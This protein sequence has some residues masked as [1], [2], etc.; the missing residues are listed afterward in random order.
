MKKK[1]TLATLLIVFITFDS[2]AQFKDLGKRIEGKIKRKID[3]KTDR[4]IDKALN[5]G[6]DKIDEGVNSATKKNTDESTEK[7][8]TS[9]TFDFVPGDKALFTDDLQ[10]ENTGDFPSKWN[11]NGSG[12]VVVADGK[13]WLK[14]KGNSFY[15]PQ[16]SSSLPENY[17]I[18]FDLAT[19]G[20]NQKVSSTLNLGIILDDNSGFKTGSNMAMAKIY[21]AQYIPIGVKVSNRVSGSQVINNTI[22]ED[23]RKALV[24][25]SKVSITVNKN[26]FRLWLN[27][28]KLVDIPSLVPTAT[29]ALKFKLEGFNEDF[30]QASISLSNLRIAESGIDLRSKLINEGRVSTN[31][32]LFDTGSDRLKPESYAVIEQIAGALNQETAMKITIIG[33]T[34]A[35]GDAATNLDLSKRRAAAVK[36]ALNSRFAIDQSRLLTDGKGESKPVDNNATAQGKANNRRVEFVKN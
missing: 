20:L 21:F 8:K 33:H 29:K 19:E 18:E 23:F 3:Q 4:T 12:E 9:G 6:E 28:N 1:L 24:G 16:V 2:N 25:T 10:R 30:K 7:F 13:K 11:T 36:T 32:I 27:Q 5:K 14:F 31:A 15:I 34:D 26:R 22:N 17:T 35:D